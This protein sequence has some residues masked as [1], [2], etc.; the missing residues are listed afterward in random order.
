MALLVRHL[1]LLSFL[2]HKKIEN[3][4]TYI[5]QN[6]KWVAQKTP[7]NND[8]VNNKIKEYDRLA[9]IRRIAAMQAYKDQESF[10]NEL[11][12]IEEN[13]IKKKQALYKE[14]SVEYLK[15]QEELEKIGLKTTQDKEKAA[16][17][18]EKAINIL[19]P[20]RQSIKTDTTRS[21]RFRFIYKKRIDAKSIFI[22][23]NKKFVCKEFKR[24]VDAKGN[25]DII[26]G[27]FYAV[28]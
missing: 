12:K 4:V 8:T 9:A 15:Y 6:G 20:N 7:G 28:D 23:N 11:L 27:V 17:S 14:G 10:E 5:F 18:R 24:I 21:Y 3:G 1:L 16:E 13:T 26:E 25:Q 2:L 22:F 19:S